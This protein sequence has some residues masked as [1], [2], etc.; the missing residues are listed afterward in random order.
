MEE[1]IVRLDGAAVTFENFAIKPVNIEIPKGY[2]I[3]V[4]GEN[5]AGKSTLLKMILGVYQNMQGRISVCG[6]DCVKE[7]EKMLR[8]IGY[9]AEERSFFEAEDAIANEAFFLHIIRHG[10]KIFIEIC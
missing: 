6:Y 5:G 7:R 8:Q 9:I 4:Q 3:G 1:K 10:I 2:I